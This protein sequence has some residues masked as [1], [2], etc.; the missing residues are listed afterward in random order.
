MKRPKGPDFEKAALRLARLIGDKDCR[1]AGA[2]A[3]GAYGFVRATTDVDLVTR[4]PLAEVERRLRQGR[5]GARLYP[6][7]I[8]EGDFP[9]LRGVLE[10][11]PFDVIP[12]LVAVD[13]ERGRV[14][15]ERGDVQL[16]V[17]PL[18]ALLAFKM[19][20]QGPKDLM[21]AAMLVLLHPQM[22]TTALEL[23]QAYRV[24]DHFRVWLEDA[25]LA[26][27]AE[28]IQAAEAR[29]ARATP[30]ASRRRRGTT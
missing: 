3:V 19:K 2:F 29:A 7:D 10:G 8:T 21:D 5:V 12:P 11:V 13:W 17:V 14:A 25:R 4:L 20:A 28:A 9:C 23:A 1:L 22:R 18:D 6:G 26:R 24:E 30:R 27:D 16:R 15:L